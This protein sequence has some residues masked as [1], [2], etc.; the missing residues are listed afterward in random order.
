MLVHEMDFEP[1]APTSMR[2][3]FDGARKFGLSDDAVWETIDGVLLAVGGEA[4]LAE[5]LDDVSGAL[6]A[7]I[8]AEQRRPPERE[9]APVKRRR[10]L[11]GR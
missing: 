10:Q 6:A 3:M 5:Y 7:R 9:R 1:F 2:A 11:F 8:L 4:T